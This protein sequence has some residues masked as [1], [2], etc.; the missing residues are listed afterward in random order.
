[1]V[2]VI[3]MKFLFHL[4]FLHDDDELKPSWPPSHI[5]NFFLIHLF[6]T[7]SFVCVSHDRAD[8]NDVEALSERKMKTNQLFVQSSSGLLL[9]S[10]T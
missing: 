8:Q 4:I 9:I 1:M 6:L 5:M 2:V 10:E 7:I 3:I